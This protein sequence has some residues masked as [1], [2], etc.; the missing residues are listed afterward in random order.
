MCVGSRVS[1]R[2]VFFCPVGQ[3][4]R[5]LIFFFL[6]IFGHSGSEVVKGQRDKVAESS[7][8]YLEDRAKS[9]KIKQNI[10]VGSIKLFTYI[11]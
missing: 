11:R 9:P 6:I 7:S 3:R 2:T 10:G 8:S 1:N 4:D 5:F